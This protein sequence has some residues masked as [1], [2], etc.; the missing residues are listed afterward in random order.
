M[1]AGLPY[2]YVLHASIGENTTLTYYMGTVW[3]MRQGRFPNFSDVSQHSTLD[4]IAGSRTIDACIA[5]DGW[6]DHY[7]MYDMQSWSIISNVI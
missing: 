1:R 7:N 5:G 2:D 3:Y 4:M 6:H